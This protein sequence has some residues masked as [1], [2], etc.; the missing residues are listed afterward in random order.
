M[1]WFYTLLLYAVTPLILLRLL[2]RSLKTPDSGHYRRRWGERFAFIDPLPRAG[3]V[4]LHAVSVGE[5]R[6]ALPLIQALKERYRHTPLLITTM[7]PTGSE[8]VRQALG[9]SVYHVYLPYD[10]PGAARRFI[11]RTRP[12][13]AL[14]METELWPNLYHACRQ[15]NIPLLLANA[16]LSARSASRYAYIRPL[17]A[18]TLRCVTLVAAQSEADS[19]RF[20]R[21]GA[22]PSQVHVTGNIKYDLTLPGGLAEQGRELKRKIFLDRPVWIAASTHNGED[23]AILRVFER[24]RTEMQMPDLLLLLVP[25]HP[26]RFAAVAERCLAQGLVITKRSEQRACSKDTQVFLGDS[27]GELLL[28]YA[29]ADVAFVGGSLITHGGHNVLEPAL[30]GLPV[31]FGPHMFNFAEASRHLLA[32]GAAFQVQDEDSLA[33]VTGRLFAN[34]EMRQSAGKRGQKAVEANR[35]ALGRLFSIIENIVDV[36]GGE[37]IRITGKNENN[38]KKGESI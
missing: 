8:Q 36:G 5:V 32:A 4:W 34:R 6:A 26:E 10:L 22:L 2:W 16:R 27:M 23:E 35:G 18:Q 20:Q 19:A 12:S 15:A 11:T 17:I 37:S 9:N 25:R 14:I 30:L 31:V 3:C 13:L 38:S 28:F 21:L 33:A 1:R 24:L 29:A 7:T